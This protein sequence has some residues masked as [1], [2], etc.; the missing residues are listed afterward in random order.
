MAI[1][2]PTDE[3]DLQGELLAWRDVGQRLWP[4][5][6][7]FG[8]CGADPEAIKA[9][10]DLAKC[11]GFVERGDGNGSAA[12]NPAAISEAIAK[13]E[14]RKAVECANWLRN[15]RFNGPRVQRSVMEKL[16]MEMGNMAK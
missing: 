5:V 8:L 13:A 16:A 11:L 7:F 15:H 6:R 2:E 1:E 10:A 12:A 4:Y 9:V 3:G 14:R